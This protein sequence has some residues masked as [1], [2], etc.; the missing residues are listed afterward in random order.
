MRNRDGGMLRSK[1]GRV[2]R[3]SVFERKMACDLMIEPEDGGDGLAVADG[4]VQDHAQRR[5]EGKQAS[6]DD[7]IGLRLGFAG[8]QAGGE[9]HGHGLG[10]EAGAGIEM[11]N[12]PPAGSGVSGF[13]QQFAFGGGKGLFAG[14]DASGGQLPEIVGGGVTILAL[15]K[16][17]RGRAGVVHG[18]DDDGA[19][20]MNDVAAGAH[21]A[22]LLDIVRADPEHRAAVDDAGGKGAGPGGIELGFYRLDLGL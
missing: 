22:R 14:I 2:P 10:H 4:A 6:P 5:R 17:A 7:F 12:A 13:L 18:E 11:K 21:S 9:K 3:S 1:A 16:N 15:Q 20:V 8:A 19:G